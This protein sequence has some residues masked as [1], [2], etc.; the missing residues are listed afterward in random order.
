MVSVMKN[1]QLSMK[2]GKT[3]PNEGPSNVMLGRQ[4][5]GP[6]KPGVSS[7]EQGKSSGNGAKGG[8]SKMFKQSG[9][10]P[11]KPA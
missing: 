7:Q 6:Q 5:T 2:K 10:K 9:S 8:S 11:L 4:R 1:K 3:M